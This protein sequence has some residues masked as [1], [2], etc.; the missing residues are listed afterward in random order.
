[1]L[2]SLVSWLSGGLQMSAAPSRLEAARVCSFAGRVTFRL[3]VS[4]DTFAWWRGLEAQVRRWLPRGMSWLRFLCLSLWQGWHHLLGTEVAYGHIYIRDRFRCTSP[5]CNRRDV[6]PHHIQFR[7]AGGSDE[8]H[9]LTSPCSWCHL[10][11]VHGG[12]VRATG[13]AQHLRWELGPQN[14]PCLII[15][16]RERMAA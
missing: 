3:R 15:D 5:V 12:R 11:G 10:L 13:T 2:G 9:N 14:A 16:G 8:A 4:R 7:S 6:T 1:M